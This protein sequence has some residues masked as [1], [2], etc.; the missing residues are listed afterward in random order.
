MLKVFLQHK[1][2][3]IYATYFHA[4]YFSNVRRNFINWITKW[5]TS[6]SIIRGTNLTPVLTWTQGFS[7]QHASLPVALQAGYFDLLPGDVGHSAL[8]VPQLLQ[9]RLYALV[10]RPGDLDKRE[11]EQQ[12]M[13]KVWQYLQE[14]HSYFNQAQNAD[15]I[16]WKL[17]NT[18]YV[19]ENLWDLM[20]RDSIRPQKL[21]WDN[22]YRLKC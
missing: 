13:N 6:S 14:R 12:I 10:Q 19:Y 4:S 3:V 5:D 22:D 20:E 8:H 9:L 2:I 16:I 15:C 21:I 11:G 1:S 17:A 18:I 7:V